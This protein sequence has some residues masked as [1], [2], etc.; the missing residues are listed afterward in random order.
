MGSW[1]HGIYESDT[2]SDWGAE[3]CR[4]LLGEARQIVDSDDLSI[5]DFELALARLDVVC[6]I[7][8]RADSYPFTDFEVVGWR[9][10]IIA[11][12]DRDCAEYR[13]DAEGASERRT[14]IHILF[15]RLE[16]LIAA[17]L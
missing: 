7:C 10:K 2:A 17:G 8:E 9:R 13:Y 16:K 5:S 11:V 4:D 6:Y 12:F 3:I 1:W 14:V 15:D